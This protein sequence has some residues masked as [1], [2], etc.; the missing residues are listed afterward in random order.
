MLFLL[1]I[2]FNLF[3]FIISPGFLNGNSVI[4]S[5]VLQPVLLSSV[6]GFFLRKVVKTRSAWIHQ[7]DLLSSRA[8]SFAIS[9]MGLQ[10]VLS[11]FLAISWKTTL[12][13]L[14]CIIV[15]C[16]IGITTNYFLKI[17]NSYMVWLLAGNCICGPAAISFASQIFIGEKKDIAK[18][19]WINTIIGFLLMIVLPILADFLQLSPDAF[20]VW[21][22]SSLQSTAQ[23]ATSAS[24]FSSESIDIA[25]MIKSFRILLLLP[26]ILFLQLISPPKHSFFE[27][28]HA[29]DRTLFSFSSLFK[30][31]PRFMVAFISLALI[32]VFIDTTG[33]VYGSGFP[34]YRLLVAVRPTVGVCSNFFLS[35]AMFAVGYLCS[36]ELNRKDCRAI[37]FALFS[38][39]QL[40]LVAYF[41]VKA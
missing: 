41:T 4:S 33:F 2:S 35:L 29:N 1:C 23:V 25:L 38:A 21:A 17:D 11:D 12:S 28:Y 19:I 40:V 31:F 24:I 14:F 3:V 27:S 30:I 16:L 6:G 39:I 22:G 32:S 9:L 37:L 10:F 5:I 34:P 13:L 18:A 36:F 15:T 26:I 20:G 7:S 8:L